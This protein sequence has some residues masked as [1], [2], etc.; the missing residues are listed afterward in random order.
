MN[1]R[2]ALLR[3]LVFAATFAGALGNPAVAPARR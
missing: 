3:F 2:C 1:Y